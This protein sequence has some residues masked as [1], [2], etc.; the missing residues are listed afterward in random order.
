MRRRALLAGLLAVPLVGAPWPAPLAA[1]PKVPR[2]GLLIWYSRDAGVEEAF[3]QGF[4]EAGFVEGQT[5]AFE[6]RWAEQKP[7]RATELAQELV[8][9]GVDVL[10]VHPTPA[11]EP[12]QLATRTIPIVVLAA[13]PVGTGAAAS[14]AR[15]G[16]NTTGVSTNAV[17]LA[18]KRLELLREIMPRMRRVAFLASSADANGPRFVDQTRAAAQQLEI[19]ML[20]QFVRGPEEFET[21][22]ATILK[23]RAEALIVQPVFTNEVRLGR[24]VAEFAL[25]HRLPT[26]SQFPQFTEVGGL[27]SY[28]A[29]SA[30]LYRQVAE[31][32]DRI[33]K[34]AR[35]ADLPIQEPTQF[36][37]ILNL[38]TAR[39]LGL[40]IPPAVLLRA[41]RTI[42][43]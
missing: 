19:Q 25:R 7:A 17:S 16:G 11:I 6:W 4:R 41:D 1:Q 36:E 29:R 42:T 37:L 5:I 15:P 24:R 20:P 30:S 31:Y 28:G 26:A 3:R 12:A 10:V 35:P 22:F 21:A 13:N 8:R 43:P 38:K 9:L 32:V 18:G 23:D 2:V 27:L 14:L 39:A 33:L 34:G 40:T